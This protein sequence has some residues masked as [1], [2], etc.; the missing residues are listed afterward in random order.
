[1]IVLALIVH[2]QFFY[3]MICICFIVLFEA[4]L[5]PDSAQ[6][7]KICPGICVPV[8]VSN[9]CPKIF[10]EIQCATANT[11]CCVRK[12]DAL[13]SAQQLI[14]QE[15]SRITPGVNFA[16]NEE[17]G[18]IEPEQQSINSHNVSSIQKGPSTPIIQD[19]IHQSN[20]QL[21]ISSIPS[22]VSILNFIN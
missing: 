14:S 1:M 2:V 15:P 5:G 11:K 21:S 12:T 18:F 7:A 8:T 20:I 16:D 9:Y 3:L 10:E 13:F 19:E 22:L 17:E 6:N 4:A